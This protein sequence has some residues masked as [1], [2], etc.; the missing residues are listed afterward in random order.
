MHEGMKKTTERMKTCLKKGV[1]KFELQICSI[2]SGM[3]NVE[4]CLEIPSK[5]TF[6]CNE[7][8]S[9]NWGVKNMP[10]NQKNANFPNNLFKI[11]DCKIFILGFAKKKKIM[12]LVSPPN[13]A[14]GQLNGGGNSPP[15]TELWTN[16]KKQI[17]SPDP[18]PR[19][20]VPCQG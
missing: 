7:L 3:C 12:Q 19:A 2:K 1:R 15:I 14:R 6:M 17:H 11:Q 9:K 13:R 18:P 16:S 8:C 10:K 20:A 5:S 4:K